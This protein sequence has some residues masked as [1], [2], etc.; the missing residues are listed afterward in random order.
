MRKLL[1]VPVLPNTAFERSTNR[2]RSRHTGVSI[3]SGVPTWK[4]RSPPSCASCP[5]TRATSSSDASPTAEK[6][7]GT[8][9]TGSGGSSPIPWGTMSCGRSETVAYVPEPWSTRRRSSSA[10][11]GGRSRMPSL[12]ASIRRSVI[13]EKKSN[14]SPS[15]T[16]NVPARTDSTDRAGSSFISTP[17]PSDPCVMTPTRV[18]DGEDM[19]G[20]RGTDRK[21]ETPR[22]GVS[23][24]RPSRW[25]T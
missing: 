5:N 15:T 13:R 11:P 10:S 2:A 19:G 21:V 18:R 16:T 17:C 20:R 23:A 9:L 25:R 24:D 1:P 14:A 6:W 22:R 8:V 3:P 4:K 12:A 7:A